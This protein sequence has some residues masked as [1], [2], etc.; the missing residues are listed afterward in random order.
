V[1]FDGEGI[2]LIPGELAAEAVRNGLRGI[3]RGA[4][5]V[6]VVGLT[7]AVA[8]PLSSARAARV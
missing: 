8:P 4:G 3:G 1:F 2:H 6:D 5:P 7:P